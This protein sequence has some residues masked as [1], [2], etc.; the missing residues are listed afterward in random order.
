MEGCSFFLDIPRE[1]GLQE[2]TVPE[3]RKPLVVIATT[4]SFINNI[5]GQ[6]VYQ[7]S[8][9][10][11]DDLGRMLAFSGSSFY[12]V[13]NSQRNDGR[14]I[15]RKYPIYRDFKI[16]EYGNRNITVKKHSVMDIIL[17]VVVVKLRRKRLINNTT[18]LWGINHLPLLAYPQRST[19]EHNG[20]HV[21][22]IWPINCVA[23]FVLE[24][25]DPMNQIQQDVQP[26][27]V[28]R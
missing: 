21:I 19:K 4:L 27:F 11:V 1:F 28:K 10:Q 14:V 13:L 22:S 5:V 9:P 7:I 26:R 16:F 25:D 23:C 3:L 24:I 17:R 15:H 18:V 20:I 8:D 2:N 12:N 6:R